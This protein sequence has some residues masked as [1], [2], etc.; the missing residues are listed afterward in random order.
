MKTELWRNLIEKVK[1]QGWK[2]PDWRHNEPL[3]LVSL[4]DF[5]IGNDGQ[6]SIGCNLIKHPGIDFFFDTLKQIRAKPNVQDVLIEINDIEEQDETIW[7]FSDTVYV[8]ADAEQKDVKLWVKS[9]RSDEVSESNIDER[10]VAAPKL[11]PGVKVFV[12]WWD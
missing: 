9:L 11:R 7:P 2:Q 5:F 8:L 4:E 1:Q 10:T 6:A 3:P 12:V